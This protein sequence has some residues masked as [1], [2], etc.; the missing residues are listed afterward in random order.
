MKTL[1]FGEAMLEYSAAPHPGGMRFG[2]D[3]LNTAIHMARLGCDVAYVTAVGDDPLSDAL[4]DA[5]A[6]EGVDT[7]FVL[8]HPVRSPGIYAIHNDEEGERSFLY[9]REKSAARAMF[10]L[11]QI[12]DAL[13]SARNVDLLYFSLISLAIIPADARKRMLSIAKIVIERGGMVAYDSNFRPRLW[14][15]RETALKVSH[16]AMACTTI[17]LPTFEDEIALSGAGCDHSDIIDRWLAAGC[18]EVV[19]KA[20]KDGCHL[21]ALDRAK[22]HFPSKPVSVVDTTGA[23]DAFNAGFLAARIQGRTVD[24]A[25]DQ[26][27]QLAARVIGQVGAIPA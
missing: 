9:W 18:S 1:I 11:P 17:G 24:E 4:V 19:V 10:D 13:D 15:D 14:P 3:T 26:A 20:G 16:A 7:R 5:W 6:A 27:Q 21:K 8:R 25:I 2:G 22:M 12:E 23:G